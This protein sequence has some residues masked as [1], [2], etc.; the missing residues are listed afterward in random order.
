[1]VRPAWVLFWSFD[2]ENPEVLVKVLDGRGENGRWW[3]DVA[4]ASDLSW[5][6]VVC[7]GPYCWRVITGRGRDINFRLRS[8]VGENERAYCAMREF[9]GVVAG[10]MRPCEIEGRG[11]SLSLRWAWVASERVAATSA[12]RFVSGKVACA[13]EPR[14]WSSSTASARPRTANTGSPFVRTNRQK[15]F[16]SRQCEARTGARLRRRRRRQPRACGN[17]G[18]EFVYIGGPADYCT[19]ACKRA[20]QVRLAMER[21][22]RRIESDPEYHEELKAYGREYSRRATGGGA[23]PKAWF[24]GRNAWAEFILENVRPRGP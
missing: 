17:C 1:M 19:V 14:P 22:R 9:R 4:V 12:T 15:R 3:L 13:T 7:K 24:R 8:P 6:T 23:R 11:T 18:A 2:I 10:P 5:E 20:V 21:R 16:C